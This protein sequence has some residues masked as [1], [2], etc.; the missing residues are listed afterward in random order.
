[1]KHQE[2]ELNRCCI[3]DEIFVGYGNNPYPVKDSGVCCDDCNPKVI[4]AR[5]RDSYHNGRQR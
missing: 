1:M 2:I 3:C 4:R 5:L